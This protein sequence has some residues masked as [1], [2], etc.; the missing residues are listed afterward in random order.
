MQVRARLYLTGLNADSERANNLQAEVNSL[1]AEAHRV[2]E[3]KAFG[4]YAD[5]LQSRLPPHMPEGWAR[6]ALLSAAMQTPG[7]AQAWD[8]SK[9]TSASF[10]IGRAAG[11]LDT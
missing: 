11:G 10:W 3:E 4:K 9:K 8:E 5:E 2:A 7:L 6:D 1:R